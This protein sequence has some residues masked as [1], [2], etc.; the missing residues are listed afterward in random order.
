LPEGI[1]IIAFANDVAVVRSGW[2]TEALEVSI[3]TALEEISN[4]MNLKD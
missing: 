4:W 1:S 2:C 3:N